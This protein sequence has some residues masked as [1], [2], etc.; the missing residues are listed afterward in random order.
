MVSARLQVAMVAAAAGH[1]LSVLMRTRGLT[2][3]TEALA[4]RRVSQALRLHAAEAEVL[5]GRIG[6][7]LA[8]L[9]AE[10]MVLTPRML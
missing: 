8:V 9:A 4:S 2:K 1:L 7:A 6:V 3:A 10:A 5:V